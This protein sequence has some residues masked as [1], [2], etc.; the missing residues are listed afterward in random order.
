MGGANADSTDSTPV[1]T[2]Q[3]YPPASNGDSPPAS[4][5]TTLAADALK[6]RQKDTVTSS[7]DSSLEMGGRVSM[8]EGESLPSSSAVSSEVYSH[9]GQPSA[10]YSTAEGTAVVSEGGSNPVNTVPSVSSSMSFDQLNARIKALEDEIRRRDENSHSR[11]LPPNGPPPRQQHQIPSP[12]Y[13]SPHNSG[14]IGH[15]TTLPPH[16]QPHPGHMPPVHQ[17]SPTPQYFQPGKIKFRYF[18]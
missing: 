14:F 18:I 10:P 17:A 13:T 2:S 1:T 15:V 16:Y 6:Y 3:L 9:T 7:S 8:S 11:D 5:A 4:I 12:Y